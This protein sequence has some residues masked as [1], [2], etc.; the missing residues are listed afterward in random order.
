MIYTSG[1]RRGFYGR[2]VRR[3]PHYRESHSAGGPSTYSAI[4]C[5]TQ[6][7]TARFTALV[8]SNRCVPTV[9][10]QVR[11]KAP[12]SAPELSAA[13][14]GKRVN[15]T[16]W[17]A[18]VRER[19]SSLLAGIGARQVRC[20]CI[21]PIGRAIAERAASSTPAGAAQSL[22]EGPHRRRFARMST[23]TLFFAAFERGRA[24]CVGVP[25]RCPQLR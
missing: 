5:S 25:P 15:P 12:G 10:F 6:L 8:S 14:T 4:R 18:C 23:D 3:G 13:R 22:P 7:S 11:R 19:S 16:F 24:Y 20:S 21:F 2:H 1:T 17:A 9:R